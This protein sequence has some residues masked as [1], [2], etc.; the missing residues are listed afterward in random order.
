MIFDISLCYSIPP[1]PRDYCMGCK[2]VTGCVPKAAYSIIKNTSH[3]LSR[4]ISI[5]NIDGAAGPLH[6]VLIGVDTMVIPVIRH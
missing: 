4:P 2:Y 1:F 6:F 5:V 3:V